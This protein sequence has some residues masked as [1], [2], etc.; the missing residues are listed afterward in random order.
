MI[1]IVGFF[2]LSMVLICQSTDGFDDILIE[3]KGFWD[4]FTARRYCIYNYNCDKTE[5]CYHEV[6]QSGLSIISLACIYDEFS[7]RVNQSK[8]VLLLH[9]P[10]LW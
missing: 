2:L 4:L 8:I 3:K 9:N 6:S 5:Y 7:F 10:Q 1:R